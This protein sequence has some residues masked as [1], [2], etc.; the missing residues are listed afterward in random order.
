M[1]ALLVGVALAAPVCVE[2]AHP[3]QHTRAALEGAVPA[4]SDEEILARL[5]HAEALSTGFPDEPLVSR[6]IAWGTFAVAQ[7]SMS[8]TSAST[9]CH[10]WRFTMSWA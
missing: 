9:S 1:I 8:S 7:G 4:V 5:V 10:S 3:E 6:T 2:R